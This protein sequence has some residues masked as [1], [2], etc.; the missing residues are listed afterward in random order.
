MHA[1]IIPFL[2]L[3]IITEN[4]LKLP[5]QSLL[6]FMCASK[7]WL[8]LIS[9]PEFVKIHMKLMAN[10]KECSQDRLI[11]RDP[12]ENFKGDETFLWNSTI[13]KLKK[14]LIL[15]TDSWRTINDLKRGF[16]I[17]FSGKFVNG[18]LYWASSAGAAKY[19]DQIGNLTHLDYTAVNGFQLN[20]NCYKLQERG[21]QTRI[22]YSCGSPIA[23][24]S[25]LDT[26]RSDVTACTV[27][28]ALHC[29]QCLL[30]P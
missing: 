4:L 26:A 14:L 19:E 17:D 11:F 21:N 12:Q 28:A 16:L 7:S 2:P 6:K 20:V 8:Q 15:K 9:S 13:R 27:S 1:S 30:I 3:E 25:Q 29:F 18:K 5:P 10:D 22:Q 24:Q 23:V